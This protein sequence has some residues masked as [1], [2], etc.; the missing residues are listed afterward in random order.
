MK[1][2]LSTRQTLLVRVQNQSDEKSWE[3][4][5]GYYRRYIYMVARNMRLSHHD[6][7]DVLQ[8]TLLKLS[9]DS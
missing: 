7:E 1:E 8:R 4:F 9:E 6:A 3:E 2:T 5:A